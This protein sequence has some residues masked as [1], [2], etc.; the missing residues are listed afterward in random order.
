MGVIIKWDFTGGSFDRHGWLC[1]L[2][3]VNIKWDFTGGSFDRHGWLCGLMGVNIKWDFRIMRLGLASQTFSQNPTIPGSIPRG[4]VSKKKISNPEAEPSSGLKKIFC[5]TE[6]DMS[7][8][9]VQ[10]V[11]HMCTAIAKD[12]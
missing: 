5:Q 8:Y 6:S 10:R 12:D 7:D 4:H 11:D 1:G 3:D 9:H 2:M